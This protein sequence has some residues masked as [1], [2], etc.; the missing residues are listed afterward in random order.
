MSLTKSKYSRRQLLRSLVMNYLM[1]VGVRNPERTY[2]EW[3]QVRYGIKHLKDLRDEQ[4]ED[5]IK[6]VKLSLNQ[7][8]YARRKLHR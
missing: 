8:K 1:Q 7:L 5:V 2:E 3:K 4:V 6:I